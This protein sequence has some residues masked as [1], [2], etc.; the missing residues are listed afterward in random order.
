MLRPTFA[1]LAIAILTAGC[2]GNAN[3]GTT[4]SI[5]SNAPT[6]TVD[7]QT[8][9]IRGVVVDGAITPVVGASVALTGGSTVKT[10]KSGLFTF[11]NLKPGDYFLTASKPG[12]T[13]VQQAASVVAGVA[14]PP[15]VKVQV[16]FIPGKQPYIE[17]FKLDGFYE[18][19]FSFGIPS[20]TPVITDQC[21]FGVRTVW[22][23][24]NQSQHS[25]P[26]VVPRNVIQG[27]NTQYFDVAAD[28]QTV[29]QEA[30]WTDETVPDMMVTLSST[31]IDNGCDCSDTDYMIVYQKSPTYARIDNETVPHGLRVAARG[32]LDWNS[33]STATN[34]QFT[35]IT[36]LF[37]NYKAAEGWTFEKQDQYPI[38]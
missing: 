11:T 33:P 31:P 25:P 22:D 19:A 38:G 5:G 8:G 36:T 7:Q 35:V 3:T 2:M 18:C 20:V 29:I 37:H 16:A 9:G 26:P 13:T 32:F 34:L 30:F 1:L 21:D 4:D 14:N 24:Y 10:D 27:T 12:Y 15:V 6:L 23:G 17:S 28:T